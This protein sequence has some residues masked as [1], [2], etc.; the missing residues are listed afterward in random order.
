MSSSQVE[1][2]L[3]APRK[4]LKSKIKQPRYMHYNRLI[5]LVFA[6][7]AGVLFQ[8]YQQG[9]FLNLQALQ[10]FIA[11]MSLY[12]LVLAVLV[13]QQ[14][15]INAFFWLATRAP[16]SWPLTIR[17]TLG[18][19]YHY[20]GLHKGGAIAGTLWF[21]AF[22]LL[23]GY[24][25]YFEHSTLSGLSTGLSY[26]IA[27]LLLTITGFA[28]KQ[29]RAKYHDM[30]ERSHRFGGWLALVL[31]WALTVSLQ[32]ERVNGPLLDGLIHSAN[33]WLLT[34]LSAS[35]A[36]P[37]LRLRRVRVEI[38]TPSNHVAI[39]KFD[40]GVT[41]FA[42]SST[43]ISLN[44]LTEW[45]HFA[46]APSPDSQG[47]RLVISRAGDWTGRF[48]DKPPSHV[49]V[50]GISQAGVAY[51]EVLFKKVVYVATGSGIGP[52]L[53]HLLAQKVPIK[54]IWSTRNPRK[55]YGD[56][57]VDE[58]LSVQPDTLIWDTDASGKPNLAE[59]AYRASRQFDAEAVICISNEKLT[60]QVVCAMETRGIPAYGAIWDS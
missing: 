22:A 52:V 49:W 17:W 12:N 33:F 9:Q 39:A 38:D 44:P 28:H 11:D 16:T 45:H 53:P 35:I 13:R 40:H 4:G 21:L 23:A 29:I 37:W 54:L 55:T 5:G 18:K 24:M 26:G 51:I 59:L 32:A 1:V 27:F 19:V 42:G 7:N 57:L 10:Y 14:Y 60:W 41:P 20:G 43:A 46:N 58:I 36:L 6:V 50:K 47:F 25:Q 15:V 2:S 30:F 3:P 8:A 31:F 34:L 48:I 56:A